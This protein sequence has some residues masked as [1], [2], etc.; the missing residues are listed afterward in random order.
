M[1]SNKP[2][3]ATTT[4]SQIP[5]ELQYL[6]EEARKY[7]SVEEFSNAVAIKRTVVVPSRRRDSHVNGGTIMLDA[8]HAKYIPNRRPSRC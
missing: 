8:N 4:Q 6:L 7:K 2:K 3:I 5:Q 1:S